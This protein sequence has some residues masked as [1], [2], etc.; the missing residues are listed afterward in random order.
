MQNQEICRKIRIHLYRAELNVVMSQAIQKFLGEKYP[1]SAKESFL[2]ITANNSFNETVSILNTLLGKDKGEVN[3]LKLGIKIP[4]LEIIRK[5]FEAQGFIVLRDKLI[6]HKDKC[7]K[8]NPTE[9]VWQLVMPNKVTKLAEIVKKL[10]KL[11]YKYFDV[12]YSQDNP[13]SKTLEG[14]YEILEMI[15]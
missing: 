2:V 12:K 15:E 5:E 3:L 11:V 1:Y 6:S 10:N 9:H 7:V 4:E 14:L 13:F 8:N